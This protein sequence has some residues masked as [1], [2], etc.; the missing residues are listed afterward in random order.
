MNQCKTSPKA[1]TFFL[2]GIGEIWCRRTGRVGLWFLQCVLSPESQLRGIILKQSWA[3]CKP[4]SFHSLAGKTYYLSCFGLLVSVAKST[5]RLETN[6]GWFLSVVLFCVSRF[7]LLVETSEVT[8]FWET[9]IRWDEARR[10]TCLIYLCLHFLSDKRL[11][12]HETD[13]PAHC[14]SR[15]R[16]IPICFF[17]ADSLF[18]TG[19]DQCGSL[20]IVEIKE[21]FL[22]FWSRILLQKDPHFFRTHKGSLSLSL[23]LCGLAKRK[24][25]SQTTFVFGLTSNL[26][27]IICGTTFFIADK[28]QHPVQVVPIRIL[29]APSA[30]GFS[31]FSQNWE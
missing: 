6:L 19:F 3:A 29:S 4:K 22:D 31:C 23:Q 17:P 30:S 18:C 11:P 27:M 2:V 21:A 5:K 14:R 10:C 8:E 15:P 9:S 20:Y 13:N 28:F 24:T 26:R 16:L 12:Y 7:L 25:G 1:D